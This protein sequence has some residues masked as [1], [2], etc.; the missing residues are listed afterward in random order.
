MSAEYRPFRALS[1]PRQV[2]REG[3][4]PHIYWHSNRCKKTK[5]QRSD[6][7]QE[8]VENMTTV[9]SRVTHTSLAVGLLPAIDEIV[10]MCP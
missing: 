5:A 4:E 10:T 7:A 2:T 9:R 8:K 1:A 3:L 6:T